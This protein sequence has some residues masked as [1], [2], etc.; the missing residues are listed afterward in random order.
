MDKWTK[1]TENPATWPPAGVCL[2]CMSFTHI[3]NIAFFWPGMQCYELPNGIQLN[4]N[5]VSHWCPLPQQPG[6]EQ[7][8]PSRDEIF[9][10][11]TY[12]KLPERKENMGIGKA[13]A[14]FYNIS[15]SEYSDMEKVEAISQI[16]RMETHNG[17]TK[18]A[19]LGVIEWLLY[20]GFGSTGR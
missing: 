2:I 9:K 4:M 14:I 15:S 19:M 16:V 5:E 20:N 17:I 8:I 7:S 6:V 13:T 18:D 11:P 10:E 3:V 12:A 1:I